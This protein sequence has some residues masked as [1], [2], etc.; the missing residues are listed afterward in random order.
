[1]NMMAIICGGLLLYIL[2]AIFFPPKWYLAK[3][4][5]DDTL[6]AKREARKYVRDVTKGIAIHATCYERGHTSGI[7]TKRSPQL[8]I[9]NG[10]IRGDF[11][12]TIYL[13][14][15]QDGMIKEFETDIAAQA[16][17]Q[18]SDYGIVAMTASEGQLRF[19][20][21]CPTSVPPRDM[22]KVRFNFVISS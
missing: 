9:F 17:Y 10:I 6:K 11:S 15:D 20:D 12:E 4:K 18:D 13:K 5:E 22:F 2:Y 14:V 3:L 7:L 1:M 8:F 21:V 16:A 19:R